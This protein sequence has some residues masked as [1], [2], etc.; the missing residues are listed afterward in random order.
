MCIDPDLME[1]VQVGMKAIKGKLIMNPQQNENAAGDTDTQP[2]NVD[3][4]ID[5]AAKDIPESDFEEVG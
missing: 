5:L 3:E 1:T 4:R 2:E